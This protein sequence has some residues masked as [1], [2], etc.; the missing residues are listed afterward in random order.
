V[1]S[2]SVGIGALFAAM[3]AQGNVCSLFKWPIPL[4]Y[5]CLKLTLLILDV[6]TKANGLG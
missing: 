1:V 5:I 6:Y 2:V 3:L 4:S